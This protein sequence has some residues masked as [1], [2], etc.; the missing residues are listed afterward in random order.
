MI[1]KIVFLF[2]I[3]SLSFLKNYAQND[4]IIMW[5]KLSPEA[6]LSTKNFDFKFRPVDLTATP[7]VDKYRIDFMAGVKFWKFTLYSY[8]KIDNYEGVWTGARLDLNFLLAD[9]RLLL[10]FQER[11]FFGLND[12]SS[13]HYYFINLFQWKFND[14]FSA[15]VLGYGKWKTT[16]KIDEGLWFWGPIVGFELPYGF[17][18][19]ISET[20]DF[21][22]ENRYMTLFLLKYKLKL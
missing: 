12:V 18:F 10:H 11:F 3:L 9:K 20:V 17:G 14:W 1:K 4:D 8:S 22:Y 6:T 19:Q 21:L 15:G 16:Q 5:Y 13:N 7:E 2:I